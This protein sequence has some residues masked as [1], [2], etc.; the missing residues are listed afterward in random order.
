MVCVG[1][2]REVGVV[3]DLV[4]AA[5]KEIDD[6]NLRGDDVINSVKELGKGHTLGWVQF[7]HLLEKL[8][9]L[10]LEGPEGREETERGQER[11]RDTERET[12]TETERER[13]RV[14]NVPRNK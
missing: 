4:R 1:D 14:T 10:G 12:E 7:Q 9:H 5:V 13:E 11:E 2:S 8:V 6:L 3:D